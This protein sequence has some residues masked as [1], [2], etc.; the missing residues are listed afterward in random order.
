MG[1]RAR[2]G[3]D[4][5]ALRDLRR[6]KKLRKLTY[7]QIQEL[8]GLGRIAVHKRLYGIVPLRLPQRDAL[9]ARLGLTP[10]EFERGVAT[11]FH[12]EL[13]LEEIKA[14]NR[15]QARHLE[16]YHLSQPPA[17]RYGPEELRRMAGGLE[18]LRFRDRE[19]AWIRAVEILR[20]PGLDPEVAGEAW[21]VLGVIC[22]YQGQIAVTA[23]CFLNAFQAG[24]SERLQARTWQRF[25]MLLLFNVGDANLAFEATKRAAACYKSCGDTVGIGKTL[26]DEGVIHGNSGA[27]EQAI[28]AYQT[29]MQLLGNE[30]LENR[31][32]ALQG[33]AINFFYLGEVHQAIE[34]LDRALAILSGQKSSKMYAAILWLKGEISLVLGQLAE[35]LDSFLSVRRRY[36][37]LEMVLE[38]SLVSLRVAK[39]YCLQGDRPR[40]RRFLDEMLLQLGDVE[41]SNK[42]LGAVLAEF[43]AE[44]SRGEISTELLEQIYRKMRE[45]A[46]DAP[47]LLPVDRRVSKLR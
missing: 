41:E 25:A 35:A 33:T 28:N 18:E 44:T 23:H 30:A 24:G 37:E 11:G 42:V 45:G 31:F 38:L 10:E 27:Y 9:L 8:W 13:L 17:E 29:A 5:P 2:S 39:V 36:L 26:V 34:H 16:R 14:G 22:R 21:G 15:S 6:W 20:T 3:K 43:F 19:A 46:E 7:P 40:L 1:K 47:P 4:T 12:P 32:G